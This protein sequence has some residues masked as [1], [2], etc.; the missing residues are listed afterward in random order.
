[1][2]NEKLLQEIIT[3]YLG[4]ISLI[5]MDA[6]RTFA[7]HFYKLALYKLV[8]FIALLVLAPIPEG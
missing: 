1:M 2:V 7:R 4:V 6:H 5:G 3:I 8:A